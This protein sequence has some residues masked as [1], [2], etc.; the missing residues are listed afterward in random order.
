MFGYIF[1][2]LHLWSDSLSHSRAY[3]SVFSAC[4]GLYSATVKQTWLH[5]CLSTLE[6][7]TK[8]P[9]LWQCSWQDHTTWG[10]LSPGQPKGIAQ[11]FLSR[12][13]SC[14]E[15]LP[16]FAPVKLRSGCFMTTLLYLSPVQLW[17][18]EGGQL[19][20]PLAMLCKPSSAAWG[21]ARHQIAFFCIYLF[22]LSFLMCIFTTSVY[23]FILFFTTSLFFPF[24]LLLVWHV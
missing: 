16:H 8:L 13:S 3:V 11:S 24:Y 9:L 22:S 5:S 21:N 17:H 7:K 18:W 2:M 1:M 6:Q 15:H 19:Q 20:E 12:I 4:W 23:F 14:Q 10:C